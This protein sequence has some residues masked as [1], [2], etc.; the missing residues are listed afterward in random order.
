[1]RELYKKLIKTEDWPSI[2]YRW[3]DEKADWVTVVQD[4]KLPWINVFDP[5]GTGGIA[6]MSYN[7]QAVPSNVLIS[8]DGAIVAR[9]LFGDQ[10]KNKV[11]ELVR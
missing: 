5:R 4:Q 1:M 8:S 7:V 3:D 6:A 10:L 11:A 9:N 2:R